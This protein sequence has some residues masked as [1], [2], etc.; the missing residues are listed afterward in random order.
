MSATSRPT[1]GRALSRR[2]SWSAILCLSLVSGLLFLPAT[3]ANAATGSADLSVSGSVTPDPASGG[4]TLTFSLTVHNEGPDPSVGTTLVSDLPPGLKPMSASTNAGSCIAPASIVT[5]DLGTVAPGPADVH[6]EILVLAQNVDEETFFETH[7]TLTASTPDPDD[8]NNELF[9][10]NSVLPGNPNTADLELTS[11][12]NVPNPVTG[13]YS[14]GSTATVT[15]LGPGDATGVTLTDTL[16]PGESFVAGGSD[17]SCTSSA[18][19]VT[20]AL[21]DLASGDVDKVLIVTK[22]PK[23]DADTTIHDAYAVLATEDVTH[24]NDALDVATVVRARRDDFVAGYV[25][26]SRWTTWL[27]DATQWSHG[28]AVATVADPTVAFIGIPGGGPGGPVTIT[29][30]PCDAPFVCMALGRAN[31]SFSH[32]PRGVFGNL[33][34]VSVPSGYDASN[35]ITGIFLDNWS[36]LGSGGDPFKVSYQSGSTG[37]P[38]VLPSCGGWKHTGAPCVSSIGRTFSWWN[39]YAFADLQTVVRFTNSGTFGRGR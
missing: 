35:P 34:Q 28:D 10:T 7:V 27:N 38:N 36:V 9:V 4:G 31:A 1:V 2:Q 14:L 6:V 16:A 13:G 17:P 23:V 5:C 19:V 37:T 39:R 18:G 3:S 32:G 8:T 24:G 25:P 15:N 20:C 26:A 30:L 12:L 11:V 21:G 29:E 33:I 22:T